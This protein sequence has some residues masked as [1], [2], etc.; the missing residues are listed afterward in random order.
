M[1][2][3]LTPQR[4]ASREE[5]ER[6]L[7]DFISGHLSTRRRQRQALVSI[8]ASTPLFASGLIDSLAIID[9]LAFVEAATGKRIRLSQIEMRYFGTVE[10]IVQTFW[11]E[12]GGAL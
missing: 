5:F 7:L 8:E 6:A 11:P 1:H 2:E 10:R 9:L 4:P 12:S 3:R